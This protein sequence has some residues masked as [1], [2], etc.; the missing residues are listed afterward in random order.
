MFETLIMARH[1]P[2]RRKSLNKNRY[3]FNGA[4]FAKDMNE[5][6]RMLGDLIAPVINIEFTEPERLEAPQLE[7]PWEE[8]EEVK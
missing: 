5:A 1:V 6:M 3:R 8:A 7:A 2:D 4:R